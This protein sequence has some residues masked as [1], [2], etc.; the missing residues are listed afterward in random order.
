MATASI[1]TNAVHRLD[2]RRG[3]VAQPQRVALRVV[4]AVAKVREQVVAQTRGAR[5]SCPG[6]LVSR[7][8]DRCHRARRSRR[9]GHT[10]AHSPRRRADVKK[11]LNRHDRATRI[12]SLLRYPLRH[13]R[14]FW[15]SLVNRGGVSVAAPLPSEVRQGRANITE[16]VGFE[17]CRQVDPSWLRVAVRNSL[18]QTRAVRPG[19]GRCFAVCVA[20]TGTVSATSSPGRRTPPPC[21]RYSVV[22][23][24][25]WP[26]SQ[27]VRR[28]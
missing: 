9:R 15:A 16:C 5:P 14:P 1:R 28:S 8:R 2:R 11:S 6:V 20:R 4:A 3:R 19:R 10:C 25:L 23:E 24:G 26:T 22:G 18:A 17:G 13:E 12:R 7:G 21:A 27:P